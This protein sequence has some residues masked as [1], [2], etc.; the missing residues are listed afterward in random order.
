M[1]NPNKIQLPSGQGGLIRYFDDYKSKI[2]INAQ[3][4]VI[5]V[6]LVIVAYMVVYFF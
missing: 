1:A 5:F 3:Y 2:V 6:V 4:F